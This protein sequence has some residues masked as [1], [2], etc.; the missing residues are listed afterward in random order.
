M[1]LSILAFA[2]VPHAPEVVARVD[3]PPTVGGAVVA[4]DP[5]RPWVAWFEEPALQQLLRE[6]LDHAFDVR[7]AELEVARA[8]AQLRRAAGRRWPEV[9]GVGVAGVERF[10]RY[11]MDGA[12]NATTP[13][14]PGRIVPVDYPELGVGLVASWEL[15]A[16]GRLRTL[17][18]AARA[19]WLA[20]VSARDLVATAVISEVA[21]TWYELLAL[22]RRRAALEASV[23]RQAR[24]VEL[25]RAQL[26][27]GRATALAVHQLEAELAATRA[28]AVAAAQAVTE[29]E[30]DLHRW[31]GRPAREVPMP[32]DALDRPLGPL[33]D[34]VPAEWLRRRPDVRGAERALEAARLDVAAAR[35]AFLPSLTLSAGVGLSAFE[36]RYLLDPASV[37]WSAAGGLV[38]PVVNRSALRADFDVAAADQMEAL[39]EYERTLVASVV[40][41]Q[42]HLA[43]LERAN[44]IARERA[45]ERAAARAAVESAEALFAAGK[46]TYLDVLTAQEAAREAE[47]E[48]VQATLGQR[49]RSIA[50]YRALGGGLP[51]EGRG[52]GGGPGTPE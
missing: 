36:L 1:I 13:I 40:E 30:G 16:W 15:S 24:A 34:G 8:G 32:P 39:V 14:T 50:L 38:G 20:S 26:E 12:G 46:V 21:S 4:D 48:A 23:E 11:T 33:P 29:R 10:G 51:L 17:Q 43:G 31:L 9:G 52:G 22:E 28:E 6:A 49:L 35:A 7:A 19:R 18:G 45:Q 25:V 2:C 44:R 41:V 27:V 5:L 3:L 37:V 47:L 42:V